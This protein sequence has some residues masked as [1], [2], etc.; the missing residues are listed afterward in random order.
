MSRPSFQVKVVD[1]EKAGLIGGPFM[2]VVIDEDDKMVA[3]TSGIQGPTGAEGVAQDYRSAYGLP[4]F[5]S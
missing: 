5:A 4:R 1:C 2:V 3:S